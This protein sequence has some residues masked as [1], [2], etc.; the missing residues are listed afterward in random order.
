[1]CRICFENTSDDRLSDCFSNLVISK[2]TKLPMI[3]S[4]EILSENKWTFMLKSKYS[5]KEFVHNKDTTSTAMEH[6][7]QIMYG[8]PDS[9]NLVETMRA[10]TRK[11]VVALH[12]VS[13][14]VFS[15]PHV[16]YNHIKP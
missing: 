5:K 2:D 4:N 14:R 8:H 1:M 9:T 13:R 7:Q 10:E 16:A 11:H 15:S 3:T 12:K 6:H